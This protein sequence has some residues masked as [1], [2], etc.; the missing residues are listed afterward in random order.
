MRI[1]SEEAFVLEEAGILPHTFTDGQTANM[2]GAAFRRVSTRHENAL[3]R[4]SENVAQ[5]RREYHIL[6]ENGKMRPPNRIELLRW[7]ANGHPDRPATQ[8]ARRI[9]TRRGIDWSADT[10]GRPKGY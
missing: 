10:G 9:L 4:W 5:A 7:A 6:V 1:I 3:R 8:A 2:S